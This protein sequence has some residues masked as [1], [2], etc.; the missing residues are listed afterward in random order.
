MKEVVL[1]IRKASQH[2][3]AVKISIETPLLPQMLD[4]I[5]GE[6]ADAVCIGNTLRGLSINIETGLPHFKKIF[7]GYSGPAIKPLALRAV[8]EARKHAPHL[9]IIG[10][11]GISDEKDVIEFLMAGANAV[12]IGTTHFINPMVIP[13]IQSQL[14]DYCLEKHIALSSLTNIAHKGGLCS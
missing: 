3:L 13:R 1:R 10:C 12:E 8:W 11:G 2:F 9:P 6:G 4:I 7:A 14:M 5:A